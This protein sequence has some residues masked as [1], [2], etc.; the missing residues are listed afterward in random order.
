M[1]FPLC[2]VVRCASTARLAARPA[3]KHNEKYPTLVGWLGWRSATGFTLRDRLGRL[4]SVD[5]GMGV[6]ARGLQSGCAVFPAPFFPLRA[7]AALKMISKQ[8]TGLTETT[9]RP[10]FLIG[11]R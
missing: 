6:A 5:I 3:G 8:K 2:I 1:N 9:A 11:K 10:V 4:G 7:R